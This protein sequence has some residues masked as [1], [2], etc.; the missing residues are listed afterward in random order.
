MSEW[1]A[2]AVRTPRLNP[3][4]FPSETTLRFV[5]LV[6]FVLCG[7]ARL[8][9]HI[10][11]KT[12]QAQM[13]CASQLVSTMSEPI[14][15]SPDA[16]RIDEMV[17][18]EL[19]P[20]LERC[21]AIARPEVLWKISGI[22]LV[23][24]VAAVIYLAYPA[25]KLKTG[26][27]EPIGASG[28]SELE[29]EL[30]SLVATAR[31]PEPPHFVWNPLATGL[32]VVFGRRRRCY[33]ALSGSFIAQYFYRD[34]G[35]FRAIVLHELAH[36]H[37]GDVPKTYLTMSLWLAFL[38]TALVPS[39]LTVLW[40]LANLR[41]SDA[42]LLFLA[43]IPWTVVIVLS[44]LAVLRAREYYADLRASAWDPSSQMDRVLA[45]LSTPHSQGWRRYLRFHPDPEERRHVVQDPSRLFRLGF[46]DAFGIGI[47]AWSTVSVVAGML[48]M[49]A[50]FEGG[51]SFVFGVAI[52][53]IVPAIVFVF[54][55]GAIGIGVWRNAFASLLKGEHPSR[56]TGRLAAAFVA[57]TFPGLL[58]LLAEI[59]S[60]SGGEQSLSRL[61]MASAL[62]FNIAIYILLLV[63]CLLVF[64]WI[65]VAASAWFDVVLQSTS[66]RP[67]LLI[68]V[69][70]ALLLVIG[71]L[72]LAT[73][74][75]MLSIVSPAWRHEEVSW[76]F[77]YVVAA[78][79]PI[80]VASVAIWAFPLAASLWWPRTVSV[81]SAPWVFLD[82]AS[83]EIAT[84]E[85]VP[86]RPALLT[87][88][89]MG[90]LFWLCWEL[91]F[92]R[93]YLP[94]GIGAGIHSAFEWLFAGTVSVF[95]SGGV[96]VTGSAAFF[97]ALAAAIAAARAPRL[98][99]LCGLCAA[100]VAGFIISVGDY[101][102]F[103]MDDEFHVSREVISVLS[104]MGPG[105]LV[106]LPMA[107][108]TARFGNVARVLVANLPSS[109]SFNG[110]Q[111]RRR[112]AALSLLSKASFAALC[113][114]VAIGMAARIREEILVVQANE[115]R[116]SAERGDSDAQ[117]KLG[118]MYAQ[119]TGVLQN[120]SLA[121]Q[122][123]RRAA[124]QGHADAQFYVGQAYEK[125]EVV[126]KNDAQA[127]LWLRKAA[128]KGHSGARNQLQAMCDGGKRVVACS[129]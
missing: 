34:K 128:D 37:N 126:A 129:P 100:F 105:V 59:T 74:L 15:S 11:D 106:A 120:E 46:A 127:V 8:Y 23:I 24:M 39:L 7:S 91:L 35:S 125:G 63:S 4:A 51:M 77:A 92:F 42:A 123:F 119:G 97:Q 40:R 68:S 80:A 38:A 81:R 115:Y 49:F 27:F 22:C 70:T 44:G 87:G 5:L 117:Y 94:T 18:K 64:R 79:G 113:L 36:I 30:R 41:L 13:Q 122:W 29:N 43:T 53:I 10:E 69:A 45:A 1:T 84:R 19:V 66:P 56:G 20:Q 57:G 108:V 71:A 104:M 67:L 12:T 88:T 116:A 21:V 6:I 16:G 60:T 110:R 109:V 83:P 9:G 72:A 82:R 73:F 124:E 76:V 17:V 96:L 118:N 14:L 62:L 32:P 99:V 33:V 25:W 90:L 111:K 50:P 86:V 58:M 103:S 89:L 2:P 52:Q 102:F 107:I 114:V 55:I 98:G 78:G 54:A 31:L 95:G 93:N 101:F 3:F 85:P 65:S 75:V 47:A 121:L 112:P 48:V 28:L 26:R 61:A